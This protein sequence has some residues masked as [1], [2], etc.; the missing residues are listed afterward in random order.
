MVCR[1]DIVEYTT[2][3]DC[4]KRGLK[5]EN[6]KEQ[7]DNGGGDGDGG[8][9]G[10]DAVLTLP[11]GP[12]AKDERRATKNAA[13]NRTAV[14]IDEGATRQGRPAVRERSNLSTYVGRWR[15]GG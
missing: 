13:E 1:T 6:V 2:T 15:L 3:R 4:K 14:M 8:S 12:S 11:P 7:N 9:G 5:G 10:G